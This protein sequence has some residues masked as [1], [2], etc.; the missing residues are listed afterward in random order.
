MIQIT[1]LSK[2]YGNKNV[3]K[4][5]NLTFEK[6]RIYGIV[7]ENGAGKTT[8]FKCICGLENFNGTISLLL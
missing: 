1:S 5:I 3:L 2:N 8:L 7:G 4:E 6:G